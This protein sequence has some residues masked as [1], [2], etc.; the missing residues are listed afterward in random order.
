MAC[1]NKKK[2]KQEQEDAAQAAAV[3]AAGTT[4]DFKN[5]TS[6]AVAAQ[7]DLLAAEQQYGPQFLAQRLKNLRATMAGL[8]LAD[9][10]NA[11]LLD[12][13][14]QVTGSDLTRDNQLDPNQNRIVEQSSRTG[15]AARGMGFG[16]AD[17][18]R[19][20]FAK[21]DFGDKLRDKRRG[22]AMTLFQLRKLIADQA[23]AYTVGANNAS[24]PSLLSNEFSGQLLGNAY[25]N[26]ATMAR[27]SYQLSQTP[28]PSVVSGG[29]N[30]GG[31]GTGNTQQINYDPYGN[32]GDPT[33]SNGGA[34]TNYG[35]TP[36]Y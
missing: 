12:Q 23:A 33:Q 3:A 2:R 21:L 11:D 9:P 19:E 6:S 20:T 18:F 25:G 28:R 10:T 32:S 29:S 13:L 31:F 36:A 16:P 1:N 15:A 4:T 35:N 7:P 34:Y 5:L 14:S 30:F 8:R 27:L 24:S 17:A 22:A 26:N